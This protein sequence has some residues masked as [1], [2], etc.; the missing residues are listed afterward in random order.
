VNENGK[1]GR[2]GGAADVVAYGF[3]DG[4]ETAAV[5]REGATAG[6]DSIVTSGYV[7]PNE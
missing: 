4:R 5:T 6:M 1:A 7:V 3:L 2:D